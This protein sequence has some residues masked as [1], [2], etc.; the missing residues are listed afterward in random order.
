MGQWLMRHDTCAMRPE[1]P[2]GVMGFLP[3]RLFQWLYVIMVG[4]Q[5][6]VPLVIQQE[7]HVHV[8]L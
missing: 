5:I 4:I 1:V 8:V 6:V 3:I 2:F 7:F